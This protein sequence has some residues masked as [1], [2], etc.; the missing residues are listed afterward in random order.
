MADQEK[1]EKVELDQVMLA[2]DVVDLLRHEQ[3]LVE[4]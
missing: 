1:P 4:R 3:A 2:M